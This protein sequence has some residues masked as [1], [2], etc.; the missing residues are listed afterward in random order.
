MNTAAE[1]SLT[2]TG[3]RNLGNL[4]HFKLQ[5]GAE[6]GQFSREIGQFSS[7]NGRIGCL[8]DRY[9]SAVIG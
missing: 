8:Y 9:T 7:E 5:R 1:D 3:E 6:I 2:V 4:K